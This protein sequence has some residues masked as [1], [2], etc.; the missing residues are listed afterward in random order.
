MLLQVAD[1]YDREVGASTKMMT[2][3]LAPALILCVAVVVAFIIVSL[4]LP[5]FQLSAG[6]R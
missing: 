1:A 6:I 5:I 4:I 3:L 2:S